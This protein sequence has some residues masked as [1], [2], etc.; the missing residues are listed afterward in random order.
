MLKKYKSA[1]EESEAGPAP[2]AAAPQ[3][4]GKGKGRAVTV[5]DEDE[6]MDGLEDAQG[7]SGRLNI[8]RSWILLF[9][10]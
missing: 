6:E 10:P 3:T 2:T 9:G 5:Q 8:F 7:M 4:N 1:V